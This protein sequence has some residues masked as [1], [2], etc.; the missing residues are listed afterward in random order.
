MLLFISGLLNLD[1][2][3]CYLRLG[4]LAE[5]PNAMERLK[6]CENNFK[7][8]YGANL[9]RLEALKGT[10]SNEAVLYMRLHL[11]QGIASYITGQKSEA[12]LL[13]QKASRELK[14]L[15]VP[16]DVLEEV[17]AQGFSKKEARLALRATHHN[18][19]L[20]VKYAQNSRLKKAKLTEAETERQ[21][22]RRKLG[23]TLDGSWVNLGYLGTLTKM[24]YEEVLAGKALRHTNNDIDQ[25]IEVMN[26]RPELLLQDDFD[27]QDDIE[28]K[29]TK[30]MIDTVTNMGFD[31][32]V[33]IEALKKCKGV[34]GKALDMLTNDPQGIANLME[35]KE[36]KNTKTKGARK[37]MEE[38]LGDDEDHL[39]QTLEEEEAYLV[40]YKKI[41]GIL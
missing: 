31:K 14:N 9:E 18:A 11:L 23:R 41:L 33:A 25:A 36:E 2:A 39:N 5:L 30:E 3:W 21:K 16:Q 1:I 13:I 17:Q 15:Q 32:D 34:L 8:S 19:T 12:N 38:D 28:K 6:E 37:R 22:M 10:T 40:Q 4:N 24:G 26:D 35:A 7:K 20:A 27:D 29:V